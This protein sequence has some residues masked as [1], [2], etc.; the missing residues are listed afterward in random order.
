[1]RGR[2]LPL[3]ALGAM[4]ALAVL[5]GVVP[6]RGADAIDR[7]LRRSGLEAQL[8]AAPDEVRAVLLERVAGESDPGR[9]R[10]VLEVARRAFSPARLRASVRRDLGRLDGPTRATALAFLSSRSGARVTRAEVTAAGGQAAARQEGSAE[11]L[12]RSLPAERQRLLERL[13]LAAAEAERRIELDERLSAAVVEGVRRARPE[14]A[15]PPAARADG[16][17]PVAAGLVET[18]RRAAVVD[19]AWV[20]REVPD[21]DLERYVEFVESGPGRR[22]QAAVA[23]AVLAALEEAARTFGELL[24]GERSA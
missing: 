23:A 15:P 5:A 6:A 2:R 20:Y 21:A 1:M 17:L 18:Y 22:F 7:L 11:T 8:A 9:V 13:E 24:A 3:A 4:A 19:A 10:D 12:A 14:L 16:G